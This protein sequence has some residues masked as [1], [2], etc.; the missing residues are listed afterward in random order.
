MLHFP[1]LINVSSLI[2]LLS[3]A[4]PLILIFLLFIYLLSNNKQSTSNPMIKKLYRLR[5]E[6]KIAGVCSGIADY[7]EIDPSL[8]RLIWLL[9]LFIAGSGLV[10]YILA[11]IVIPIEPLKQ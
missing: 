10:A 2:S 1:Q 3:T 7:F 6:R 9:T 4:I 8:V 11:I 5:N